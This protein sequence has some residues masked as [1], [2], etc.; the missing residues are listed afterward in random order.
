LEFQSGVYSLRFGICMHFWHQF[1]GW[2]CWFSFVSVSQAFRRYSLNSL[3]Q[4][5][6]HQDSVQTPS[7]RGSSSMER[8][9]CNILVDLP[10]PT[11]DGES[12]QRLKNDIVLTKAIDGKLV[13]F[14]QMKIFSS[15]T[16]ISL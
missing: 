13:D 7:C 12:V 3:R 5:Q 9:S 16:L 2:W 14:S 15:L 4:C 6:K 10:L 11:E 1:L 8:S